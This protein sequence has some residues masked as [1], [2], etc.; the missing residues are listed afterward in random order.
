MQTNKHNTAYKWNKEQKPHGHLN[1]Y[2]GNLWQNF[3][4]L[5][6][7]SSDEGKNKSNVP[8]S[9][10]GYKRQTIANVLKRK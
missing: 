6:D 1:K 7:I 4:S 8:Q 3:T 5:H 10:K 2:R 9:N